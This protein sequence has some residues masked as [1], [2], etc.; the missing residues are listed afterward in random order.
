M[1]HIRRWRDSGE[2][3]QFAVE[4]HARPVKSIKTGFAAAVKKAGLGGGV[5]PHTLRH[6]RA[7][8]MMQDG[9][10]IW[11]AAGALGM[12]D[13]ILRR[14]YGHHHPDHQKNA[15]NAR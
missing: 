2:C 10:A 7:T 3:H 15:V 13:D 11:E 9:V 5:S 14:V 12:S 8:H 1:A 4:W 6:S